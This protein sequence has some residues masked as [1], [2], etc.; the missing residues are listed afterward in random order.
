MIAR[1]DLLPS[2]LEGERREKDGAGRDGEIRAHYPIVGSALVDGVYGVWRRLQVV[3]DPS[4]GIRPEINSHTP[5]EKL[6]FRI[7]LFRLLSFSI[8]FSLSL[9]PLQS[10][11]LLLHSTASLSLFLSI[12]LT[13]SVAYGTNSAHRLIGICSQARKKWSRV[14]GSHA[15]CNIILASPRLQFTWACYLNF[16]SR[17]YDLQWKKY[18]RN[19]KRNV[20]FDFSSSTFKNN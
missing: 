9:L 15:V 11:S 6:Y 1:W 10:F 17:K 16:G 7:S 8:P 12:Y 2:S 3:T 13:I 20:L 5:R 18:K 19:R 4:V 14:I